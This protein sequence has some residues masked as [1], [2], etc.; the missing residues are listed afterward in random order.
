ME[1]TPE[2]LYYTPEMI[3]T[4][5]RVLKPVESGDSVD[6]QGKAYADREDYQYPSHLAPV[7][8]RRTR[9]ATVKKCIE[10]LLNHDFDTLAFSGMSGAG[11]GFV[12]AHI[13]HKEVILIRKPGEPRRAGM[14]YFNEG[15]KDAKRYVIIDDLISTGTTAARVIRG[16]R[17]L[18]PNAF[19]VGILT[20]FSGPTMVNEHTYTWRSVQQIVE[21]MDFS[22][23]NG[24]PTE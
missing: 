18:C 8:N 10:V 9:D 21:S 14:T 19:L 22:A 1:G 4:M 13:L 3:K 20:Y 16:V 17:E 24:K 12:L 2:K 6:S 7:L 23:A 5:T 11:I 15:Y